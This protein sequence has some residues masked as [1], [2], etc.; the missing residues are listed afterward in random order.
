M[1]FADEIRI[2]AKSKE[3]LAQEETQRQK[4]R[5]EEY[6]QT[7]INSFERI[8]SALKQHISEAAQKGQF[9]QNSQ[10]GKIIQDTIILESTFRDREG[11]TISYLLDYCILKKA[12]VLKHRNRKFW[13]KYEDLW[14]LSIKAKYDWFGDV[15]QKAIADLQQ[16]GIKASFTL[17]W[18]IGRWNTAVKTQIYHFPLEQLITGFQTEVWLDANLRKS[19]SEGRVFLDT[20]NDET[21]ISCTYQFSF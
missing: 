16:E 13:G 11:P 21:K 12:E 14:R 7:A 8:K 20:Y 19:N 6:R 1:S 5:E 9:T 2:Q 18:Q 3:E 15:L 4:Q 17:E 10:Y